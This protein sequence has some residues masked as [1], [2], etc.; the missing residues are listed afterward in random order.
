MDSSSAVDECRV[1]TRTLSE[2]NMLHWV[3]PHVKLGLEPTR[4]LEMPLECEAM[5]G[6]MHKLKK[7]RGK[8]LATCKASQT[9]DKPLNS[10]CDSL[11]LGM[12]LFG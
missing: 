5:R 8:W 12:S 1:S 6:K 11:R 3:K 2:G 4:E 7:L 10:G 9:F